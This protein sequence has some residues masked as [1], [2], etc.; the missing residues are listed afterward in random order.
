[1]LYVLTTFEESF[2]F[3]HHFLPSPQ[4]NGPLTTS[5]N[6]WVDTLLWVRQNTPQDAVFAVDS[7]YLLDSGADVHGF[8]SISERSSLADYFK[9][10]GVVSLFPALAGEWKEMSNATYGLNHFQAQD[11]LRLQGK[12][13]AISWTVI[14]GSAPQGMN[15][16][17]QEKGY[18]VCQLAPHSIGSSL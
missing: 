1:M 9:D 5:S 8:R 10:G 3:K 18:A 4:I 13:P 14:H 11:F 15:C 12:Y 6:A 7:R 17:H 16:P 2:I